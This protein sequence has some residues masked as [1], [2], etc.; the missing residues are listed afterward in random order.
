MSKNKMLDII[1][2][3]DNNQSKNE[4]IEELSDPRM[5]LGFKHTIAKTINKM[6][7]MGLIK[8]EQDKIT[9]TNKGAEFYDTE[10]FEEF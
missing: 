8:E 5:L 7:D 6:I 1:S 2:A 3:I 9:V 10:N 4:L